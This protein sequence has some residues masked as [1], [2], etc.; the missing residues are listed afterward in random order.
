MLPT[1]HFGF[2]DHEQR[3]R[4][5]YLDL[6][7]NDASREVL[8]KRSKITKYIRDFFHERHFVEVET[9]MMTAI[10]GG[11][12]ALPFVTHH[13][14]RLSCT[15]LR[16][17]LP[18]ACELTKGGTAKQDLDIDMYMRVAPELYLKMLIVGG[19]NRVFE[20]LSRSCPP[21]RHIRTH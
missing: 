6:L 14:V 8:W 17:L 7:F 15:R 12:T 13:N 1:E 3:F 10:A 11:A 18:L 21:N 9:P 19:F 2:K 4:S 20:V 5:R 16:R